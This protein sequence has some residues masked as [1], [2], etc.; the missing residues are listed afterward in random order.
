MRPHQ[1]TELL[2]RCV[3]RIGALSPISRDDLRQMLVADRQY[4]LLELRRA[5]SGDRVDATVSCTNAA[6]RARID[7]DFALA[8]IPIKESRDKGPL[9]RMQLSPEACAESAVEEA[10]GGIVFRLPNGGDQEAVGAMLQYDEQKAATV[11]LERC[12]ERIGSQE[13]PGL[14]GLSP[15]A[16]S[17][18]E[19]EMEEVAPAVDLTAAGDCPECGTSFAIPLDLARLLWNEW[20]ISR[21]RLLR[22]VHYLAFHYHWS[23]REI[24]AMPR[25]LRREYIGILAE[26]MERLNGDG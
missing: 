24:M 1:I 20:G 13:R 14:A 19:R 17:E 22:E 5:T 23:A 18:I 3:H 21:K 11:L 16:L 2:R 26:E 8:D 10:R 12:V 9:Y 6:C 4:L 15:R 25:V 7:I